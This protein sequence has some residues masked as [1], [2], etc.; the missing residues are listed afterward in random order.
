MITRH[1]GSIF[2]KFEYE[3]IRSF[4]ATLLQ[5]DRY[6]FSFWEFSVFPDAVYKSDWNELI[7][8]FAISSDIYKVLRC[9]FFSTVLLNE[10]LSG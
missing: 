5:N 4:R 9:S 10:L 2:Q 3:N 7:E 1:K 6:F 8:I